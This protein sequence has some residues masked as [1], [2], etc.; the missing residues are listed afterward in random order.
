M[1]P[2]SFVDLGENLAGDTSYDKE[3]R[4]RTAISRIYYGI[5][6][7][8]TTIKHINVRETDKYHSE[9]VKKLKDIDNLLGV[10]LDQLRKRRVDADYKLG[11]KIQENRYD[12]ALKIKDRIFEHLKSYGGIN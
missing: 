4:Y 5:M 10:L 12:E 2:I 9:I 6:H 11:L 8:L 7:L 1:D 3:A